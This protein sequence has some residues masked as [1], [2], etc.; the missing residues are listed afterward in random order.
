MGRNFGIHSSKRMAWI[1]A[2]ESEIEIE[3]R[4]HLIVGA[5]HPSDPG[6]LALRVYEL[7][8]KLG[9]RPFDEVKWNMKKTEATKEQRYALSNE[10]LSTLMW[11]CTGFILI[12]E[13]RDKQHAVEHL[14]LQIQDYLKGTDAYILNL[15]EGLLPDPAA[16]IEWIERSADTSPRC[17]G[18]QSLD[19]SKDQILQACD[20]FVGSFR[21]AIWSELTGT[22]KTISRPDGEHDAITLVTYVHFGTRHLLW[23]KVDGTTEDMAQGTM[24]FKHSLGLGFRILSSVS[25][26][27]RKKL[28]TFTTV[29]MGC[30]S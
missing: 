12:V 24:P 19:S 4:P 2:D 23:G 11:G 30:L 18:L 1:Y 21:A 22:A 25:Q 26:E 7:K 13:G 3:G 15:D 14:A 16:F 10:I 20:I 17:M 8:E 5:I 9:F 29:Y 6:D 28:E 27:T